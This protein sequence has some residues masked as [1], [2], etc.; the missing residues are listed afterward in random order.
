MSIPPLVSFNLSCPPPPPS[1]MSCLVCPHLMRFYPFY[2]FALI[3]SPP[4]PPNSRYGCP[5]P[6]ALPVVLFLLLFC[7]PPYLL[8]RRGPSAADSVAQAVGRF[9][10]LCK[11]ILKFPGLATSAKFV[12]VPGP[13]DPGAGDTLP[14]PPV[15]ERE[16]KKTRRKIR[17]RALGQLQLVGLSCGFALP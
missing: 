13:Q 12:F 14:R 15:R 1:V 6:Y 10:S 7:P 4:P 11:L 8:S 16:K 3:C 5:L 2:C 9:D 17:K